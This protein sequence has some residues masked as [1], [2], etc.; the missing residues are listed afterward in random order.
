MKVGDLVKCD[1][2]VYGGRY[3]LVMRVQEIDYCRG[4][5]ILFP[6]GITLVR[7]ANLKVINEIS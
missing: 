1:D 2:W 5:Y 3:G 7:T 4:A 6:S